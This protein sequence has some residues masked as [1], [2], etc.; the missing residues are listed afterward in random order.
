M[1]PHKKLIVYLDQC[2]ISEIAKAQGQT[3]TRSLAILDLY[4][5]LKEGVNV[6]KIVVPASFFHRVESAGDTR[7]ESKIFHDLKSLGQ[8]EFLPWW[9]IEKNQFQNQLLEHAAKVPHRKQDPWMEAFGADPD[10][11]L[12]SHDLV[13]IGYPFHDI[14]SALN[15]A[16]RGKIESIKPSTSSN[17]LAEQYNLELDATRDGYRNQI[18][19]DFRFFLE[20]NE[21]S[22]E[23]AETFIASVAFAKIAAFHIRSLMWARELTSFSARTG[24]ASDQTD[25]QMFSTILPYADMLCTDTYMA[26]AARELKL[27]AKYQTEIFSMKEKDIKCFTQ[28]VREETAKRSPANVPPFSLLVMEF[29]DLASFENAVE[30]ISG[31]LV[32]YEKSHG[33]HITAMIQL[34]G[35]I[36]HPYFPEH[37]M[38]QVT[39]YTALV[40]KQVFLNPHAKT[41][42]SQSKDAQELIATF[43]EN[44]RLNP[45]GI[46]DSAVAAQEGMLEDIRAAIEE[47]LPRSSRFGIQIH[48][49]SQNTK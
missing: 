28:R 23:Q 19:N 33:D 38:P 42:G 18:A 11:P 7:I 27:D 2:V 29:P 47:K 36:E 12:Q 48:H 46:I 1:F 20:E 26:V 31:E 49:P 40:L 10:S 8:V 17:T 35:K 45:V 9:D 34:T 32:E 21:I 5:A 3:D 13:V 41:L 15:E 43:P 16:S 6:E 30:Q 24:K 44:F 39:P 25:I 22:P 4:Q 37:G 14:H